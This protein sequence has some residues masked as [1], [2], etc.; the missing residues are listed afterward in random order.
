MAVTGFEITLR[1]PLA[2]GVRFGEVGEYEEIKGRL[3]FAL[4]PLHPANER[5]TDLERAPRS[6]DGLVEMTSDVLILAPAERSR[7]NGGVVLDV[8]NRGNRISVPGFNDATRPVFG[9]DSDPNPPIDVGDGFLMRHGYTVV[10]C[11]W[12]KDAPDYPGLIRL[13]GPDGVGPDGEPITGRVFTQL[14]TPERA[15]HLMLSD[16]PGASRAP[17]AFGQC[18]TLTT[19]AWRAASRRAGCTR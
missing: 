9:P 17:D 6:A 2:G 5:I 19:F 1:R 16:D 14:Q 7:A 15:E 12:Q 3:R 13:Y 11:G 10:S 4:D 18:Q 8:V